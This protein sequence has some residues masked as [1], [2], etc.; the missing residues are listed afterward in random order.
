MRDP[1]KAA[2][3]AAILSGIPACIVIMLGILSDNIILII[4][5]C[6]VLLCAVTGTMIWAR[7]ERRKQD[8]S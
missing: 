5:S 3:N 4:V 2:R 6:L 8:G 7:Q 1:V